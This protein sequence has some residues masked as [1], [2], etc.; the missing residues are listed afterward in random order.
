MLGL[1]LSLIGCAGDSDQALRVE[2]SRSPD[3]M[4]LTLIA[5]HSIKINAQLKPS[6]ELKD[7]TTLRFDTPHLTADSS[8][9]TAPPELVLPAGVP[10]KGKIRAS[11]CD[12]GQA[13]CRLATLTLK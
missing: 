6:L 7:G 9:F 5:Q 2:Q 13:Y 11:V 4:R 1:T 3:G 8:Y 12:S 10:A